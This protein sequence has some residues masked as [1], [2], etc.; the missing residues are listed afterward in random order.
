MRPR[1][2]LFALVLAACSSS[3]APPEDGPSVATA[4]GLIV[5]TPER[6]AFIR[7]TN[8]RRVDVRGHLARRTDEVLKINGEIIHVEPDGSFRLSV[9]AEPGTNIIAF[10]LGGDGGIKAQRA[11]VY[12]DFVP[13]GKVSSAAALHFGRA[14][15]DGG[16][17]SVARLAEAA[18]ADLD[19]IAQLPSSYA[20]SVPVVGTV[21]VVLTSRTVGSPKLAL[22]PRTGGIDARASLPD[23]RIAARITFGCVFSTCEVTGNVM[24]EAVVVT[25]AIDVKLDRGSIVATGR[26]LGVSLPGFTYTIDGTLGSVAKS[27]IDF[28]IPDLRSRLEQ[29]VASKVAA[30]LPDRIGLALNRL[31]FPT[32]VDLRS[33]LEGRVD[34]AQPID[35]LSIDSDGVTVASS[36]ALGANIPAG[37]AGAAAP[38]WVRQGAQTGRFRVA[39]AFAV[40]VAIDTLNQF[41]HAIW[42]QG[43]FDKVQ[44][45]EVKGTLG[46]SRMHLMLPPV[47]RQESDGTATLRVGDV[48]I[49]TTLLGSPIKAAVSAWAKVTAVP[50]DHG[51][52]CHLEMSGL[53]AKVEVLAGETPFDGAGLAQLLEGFGPQLGQLL[54]MVRLPLPVL[55]LGELTPSLQGTTLRLVGP[56]ETVVGDP[57]SRLTIY[58][59]L[60]R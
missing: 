38:G 47:L 3:T 35:E 10:E 42:A 14:A 54:T 36:L 6:G 44:I 16:P 30:A 50:D 25:Q 29:L 40:S 9:P 2:A 60:G 34:M 18:L 46:E 24:A 28:F 37:S 22:A 48:I 11:F 57:P 23:P 33:P 52:S 17:S 45:P 5:E 31:S 19:I 7:A 56:T 27:I 49:E 13:L 20:L 1:L 15:L 58:G 55:P 59:D 12:G 32:H 43:A 41:L 8:E 53:K 21:T 26:D 39:P 51:W 4:Q